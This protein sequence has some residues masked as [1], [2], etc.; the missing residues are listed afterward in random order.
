MPCI[1]YICSFALVG[2]W[3]ISFIYMIKI[4]CL[5][6]VFRDY[7]FIMYIETDLMFP[8]SYNIFSHYFCWIFYDTYFSLEN[9]FKFTVLLPVTRCVDHNTGLP[10]NSNIWKTVRVNVAFKGTFFKEYLISFVMIGKLIDFLLV[11]L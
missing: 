9:T 10:S 4:Y 5:C 2:N 3:R 7:F 6:F 11:I 8:C 1:L